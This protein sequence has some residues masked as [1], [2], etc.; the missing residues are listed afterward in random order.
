MASVTEA[1]DTD[2]ARSGKGKIVLVFT[3][4]IALTL[5][6]WLTMSMSPPARI[7]K[8]K[9]ALATIALVKSPWE[10]KADDW[11]NMTDA[12]LVLLES[13]GA[14]VDEKIYVFGGIERPSLFSLKGGTA[15]YVYDP[16]TDSWTQNADMPT[17]V[18]HV[19]T[20]VDGQVIWFA[21]G[22]IGSR[23]GGFDGTTDV[24]AYD[25]LADNW[26]KGPPLPRAIASGALVRHER[27]LHF[28]GG[29][30]GEDGE[31]MSDKHWVMDLDGGTSWET[32]APIPEPRGHISTVTLNNKIYAI[33]GMHGH[34]VDAQDLTWVHAYDPASDSWTELASLPSRRS[35][36]ESSTFVDNGRIYVLGGKNYSDHPFIRERG[37]PF[38]NVYDPATDTWS[39]FPG[40][41]KGLLGPIA[42]VIDGYLYVTTGSLISVFHGQS[43][44]YRRPW[45]S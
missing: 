33:G 37:L 15:I 42:G 20:A 29:F 26:L 30:L 1:S 11:E 34:H 40:L 10:E 43:A 39:D 21:G 27:Q 17:G 6:L 14:I 9:L 3:L 2:N 36:M 8:H 12:P 16:K 22:W 45:K 13:A 28:F 41:P 38:M 44:T 25:T 35:H 5:A 18:T 31:R 24:W 32:L 7:I 19:N 4:I 23:A